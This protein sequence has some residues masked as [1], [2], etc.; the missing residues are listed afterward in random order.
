MTDFLVVLEQ[1]VGNPNLRSQMEENARRLFVEQFSVEKIY[2]AMVDY[3]E[4]IATS[5][6]KSRSLA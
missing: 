3:L 1:L 2:P 4:Q 6:F 5:T